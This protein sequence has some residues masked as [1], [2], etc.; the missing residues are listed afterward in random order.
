MIVISKR[1]KGHYCLLHKDTKKVIKSVG[2][3]S[4][5]VDGAPVVSNVPGST[6]GYLTHLIKSS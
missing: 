4:T 3:N 2:I 5:E 1:L 6:W